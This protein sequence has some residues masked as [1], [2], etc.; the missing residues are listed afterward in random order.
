MKDI[1]QEFC[2]DFDMYTYI[3]CKWGFIDVREK[4][5]DGE[6]EISTMRIIHQL[7]LACPT[8]YSLGINPTTRSYALTGNRTSDLLVC[9]LMLNL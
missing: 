5:E 4:K 9:R 1:E 7:P 3:Y 2:T 6:R 8:P